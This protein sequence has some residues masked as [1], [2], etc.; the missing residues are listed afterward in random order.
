MVPESHQSAMARLVPPAEPEGSGG[1]ACD[2][3][4]TRLRAAREAACVGRLS[5]ASAL[6]G[7]PVSTIR[8]LEA[9]ERPPSVRELQ[10]LAGAYTTSADW[11]IGLAG[12]VDLPP[13]AELVDRAAA[14]MTVLA[15]RILGRVAAV[16]LRAI[17]DLRPTPAHERT[18]NA[19]IDLAAA[20]RR[21]M[22]LN[23]G[24][25]DMAGGSMVVC[26]LDALADLAESE[27]L[28]LARGRRRARLRGGV[29]LAALPEADASALSTDSPG[30]A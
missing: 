7:L 16:G 27:A 17:Q 1:T 18:V 14:E 8:T 10:C 3:V 15:E 4:A 23:P 2:G 19:A 12:E 13:G 24:F 30:T 11:L 5:Q 20:M 26:R 28:R 25:V 21:F 6:T 22:V 9:G 29:D